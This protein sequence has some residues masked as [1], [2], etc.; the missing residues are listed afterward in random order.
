VKV[1]LSDG[2]FHINIHYFSQNPFALC[3]EVCASLNRDAC[4]LLRGAERLK[5]ESIGSQLLPHCH[6][7]LSLGVTENLV[8]QSRR[9]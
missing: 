7:D 5:A 4:G 8:I 9:A 2:H 1:A 3:Q 6:T